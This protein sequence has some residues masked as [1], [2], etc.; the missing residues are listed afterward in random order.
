MRQVVLILGI[1]AWK[2]VNF[3]GECGSP[4]VTDGEFAAS[5]PIP[6]SLSGFLVIVFL[7]TQLCIDREEDRPVSLGSFQLVVR[8]LWLMKYISPAAVTPSSQ[9]YGNGPSTD[10]DGDDTGD[11][12][13]DEVCR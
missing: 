11:D 3:W 12:N 6:T 8:S 13:D 4:M 2:W 5:R 10:D 7:I 9:P 1:D